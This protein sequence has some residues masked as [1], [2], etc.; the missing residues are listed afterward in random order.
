MKRKDLTSEYRSSS[1]EI[2]GTV[3]D[4][5]SLSVTELDLDFSVEKLRGNWRPGPGVLSDIGHH[6]HHEIGENPRRQ[7]QAE[8]KSSEGVHSTGLQQPL[9]LGTTNRWE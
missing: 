9:G 5:G 1:P 2:E 7:V 8:R 6:R 3:G 4:K